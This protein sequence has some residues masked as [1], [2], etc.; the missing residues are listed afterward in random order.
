MSNDDEFAVFRS[1]EL[2]A[3]STLIGYRHQAG[4]ELQLLPLDRGLF[5]G[6]CGRTK[7]FKD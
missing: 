6:L 3:C 4:A 5:E 7:V 2:L 1:V